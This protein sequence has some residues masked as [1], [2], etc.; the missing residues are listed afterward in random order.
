[1]RRD[2]GMTLVEVL[3]SMAILGIAFTALLG[4]IAAQVRVVGIEPDDPAVQASVLRAAEA[5]RSAPLAEPCRASAYEA[6]AA[7]AAEPYPASVRVECRWQSEP[8]QAVTVV[9]V[10]VDG[11]EHATTL[12]KGRP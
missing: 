9:V 3:V 5:V 7:R 6:V 10:D 2:E 8:L 1:M 4:A 11:R 12:V